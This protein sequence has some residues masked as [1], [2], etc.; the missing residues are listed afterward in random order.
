MCFNNFLSVARDSIYLEHD[1]A[2]E[3]WREH[4]YSLGL[5]DDAGDDDET[6]PEIALSWLPSDG[7]PPERLSTEDRQALFKSLEEALRPH[8]A[9]PSCLGLGHTNISSKA[10]A[11]MY[12]HAL[13]SSDFQ[14]LAMKNQRVH[15]MC[16][17]MGTELG[18]PGFSL[19]NLSD[20][21]P[22]WFP[23]HS[24]RPQF[25]PDTNDEVAPNPEGTL[26]PNAVAIPGICHTVHNLLK[27]VDCKL[28]HWEWFYTRLKNT[29]AL[30]GRDQARRRL[31]VTCV[32]GRSSPHH[33]SLWDK[34]PPGLYEAR[35]GQV[36]SYL[37]AALP[38]LEILR[39]CWDQS[40]YQGQ[41]SG[42]GEE[43]VSFDIKL[44]SDTLA[45]SKFFLYANM[46]L[47]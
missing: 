34:S 23:W 28:H 19:N 47:N 35:W 21:F 8:I 1:V 30:L 2:L 37:R 10:S 6:E 4:R 7:A 16:T 33:E 18:L 43:G 12:S 9:L 5:A 24:S 46:V 25:R 11:L 13:E 27:D 36:L 45:C 31:L 44:F 20:I 39:G 38:M 42:T 32:Q 15:A 41:G 22:S 17:D 40:I 29:C 3:H 14:D 26:L